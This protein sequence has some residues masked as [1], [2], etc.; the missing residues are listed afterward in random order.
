M[1]INVL[2][3]ENIDRKCQRIEHYLSKLYI[4]VSLA[5]FMYVCVTLTPGA[6]GMLTT[7]LH[8]HNLS[9]SPINLSLRVCFYMPVSVLPWPLFKRLV[10][11]LPNE[12]HHTGDCSLRKRKDTTGGVCCPT[13]QN[14]QLHSGAGS[15]YVLVWC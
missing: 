4:F 9:L 15:K 14:T 7:P 12:L 1:V 13:R 2:G 10:E 5:F 11:C 3:V 8:S 6:G